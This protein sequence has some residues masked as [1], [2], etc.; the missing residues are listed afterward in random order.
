MCRENFVTITSVMKLMSAT[1]N[2]GNKGPYAPSLT[3]DLNNFLNCTY[4][5]LRLVLDHVSK[6]VLF[7]VSFCL[8]TLRFNECR[9]FYRGL[10]KSTIPKRWS[11][12]SIYLRIY[13]LL[14]YPSGL[15]E[16]SITKSTRAWI[17]C[18]SNLY[19]LEFA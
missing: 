6:L 1:A 17:E 9:N 2:L 10:Y 18:D 11:T 12:F 5:L 7:I 13:T 14:A 15:L 8:R 16:R 19:S 4:K 3:L